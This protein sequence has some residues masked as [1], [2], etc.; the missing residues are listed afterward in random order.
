VLGV[1]ALNSPSSTGAADSPLVTQVDDNTKK[2]DN[3]EARISNTESDVKDLQNK[4]NTAPSTNHVAVPNST[5]S[6]SNPATPSPVTVTAYEQQPIDGSENV[7]CRYTYSDG[8]NTVFLWKMVNEQGSWQTDGG[9]QNGHWVKKN[10]SD[11]WVLRPA[12]NRAN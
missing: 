5:P 7:N 11:K 2:L 1:S 12:R 8:S 10:N 9:G 4:T 3:H 6:A